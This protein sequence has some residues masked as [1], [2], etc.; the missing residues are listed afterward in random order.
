MEAL[1]QRMPDLRIG[2]FG[3]LFLDRYLDLD[4]SLTEPS[5]ETG[6]DAY[7]V[8]QVRGF[9]GAAG[10]VINNLA[11]L[12]VGRIVPVAV[13]GD[14]GEGYELQQ[15]LRKLKEVDCEG[16]VVDPRR[17][18]PTYTKPM[19]ME[20]GRTPRELNRLD[21][22]NRQ[23]LPGALESRLEEILTRLFP[24]MDGW[25]VLDQVSQENCG[26]VTSHLREV[27]SRLA[28]ARSDIP[29]LADSRERIHLFRGVAIKPN[30]REC[31]RATGLEPTQGG[32]A[33]LAQTCVSKVFCTSGESGILVA[34]HPGRILG[35]APAYPVKGPIDPVGAGDSTSAGILTAL[36]AGV[37]PL[38]AA[39]FGNLI[40][41]ITVQQLGT[42]GTANPDQVRE[43][44]RQ[45]LGKNN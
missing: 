6:L 26:V 36:A 18:T 38:I 32:V 44:G 25:V 39:S 12:G 11:A 23:S 37:D 35:E 4:A 2:V 15:A 29:V 41:S 21:I 8:V 27:L 30:Q 22:H 33:H 5:L 45:V 13:I 24:E 34:D 9:P 19:L 40:A 17:R 16:I 20:S 10:T 43:R 3:D 31:L 14:D 1:L 7:Q 28:G 42:T